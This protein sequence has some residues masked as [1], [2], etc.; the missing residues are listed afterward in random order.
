[1]RVGALS[2]IVVTIVLLFV[3]CTKGKTSTSTRGAPAQRIVSISPSTTEAVFAVGAGAK[4]VGRSRYCDFPPEVTKIPQVGGYVDPSFE[5][6]LALQP[7]LVIGARGPAGSAIAEKLEARGIATYFPPTESFAAI[8]EMILGI[9]ERTG[10]A[11][12]A[13]S[14]VSSIH[15]QIEVV[16]R[17]VAPLPKTRAL[18]VFGLSPL[19][20][21]GPSSF[22][23][24]MIRRAGG[25]NVITE[26]GAYPTIGAEHV[27]ALDP[28][29]VINAAMMEERAT[30]R[31]QKD[32]PGWRGVRAVERG[33]VTSITDEAVLRPGPRIA[34]GLALL[35]RAL[36]PEARPTPADAAPLPASIDGAAGA[37]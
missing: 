18:L 37:P 8:D 36:H 26:G 25:K 5:T 31:L 29:V 17:M 12:A 6:I 34:E 4:L 1:V 2:F 9:G 11:D 28:D 21:A 32:A 7:D 13:R 27:L 22:A 24:E 10:R 15:A 16:E 3:G 14:S 30:E 35:A 33:N 20:V 19:S 23:D